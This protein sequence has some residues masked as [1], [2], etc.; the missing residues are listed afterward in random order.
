MTNMYSSHDGNIVKV[1]PQPD[2]VIEMTP[3]EVEMNLQ[4]AKQRLAERQASLVLAEQEVA[5]YE[6]MLSKCEELGV[7]EVKPETAVISDVIVE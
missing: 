4:W 6:E 2:L 5:R 1:I 7:S 3:A